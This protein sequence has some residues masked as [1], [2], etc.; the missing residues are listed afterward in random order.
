M[1]D[2]EA[3][4]P[5]D[6][7]EPEPAPAA[8]DPPGPQTGPELGPEQLGPEL[9]PACFGDQEFEDQLEPYH[10]IR[11]SHAIARAGI[12]MLGAGASA[13]RVR[14]LMRKVALSLGMERMQASISFTSVTLTVSRRDIFRT[15]VSEVD[16]P[17]ID[18]QRIA[19]LHQLMH[20]LP[21][22]TTATEVDRRLDEIEAT[23]PVYSGWVVAV[24]V[25][26]A[27]ASVTVLN[28]G[29][30]REAAAAAP[31]SALAYVLH[32]A[33]LR[34]RINLLPTML[35]SAFVT[36]ALFAAFTALLDASLGSTSERMPAGFVCAAIWLVPGFPLVTGG[37]DLTRID[38]DA[39]IPRVVHA[40]MVLLAM[41]IGVWLVAWIVHVS[42]EEIP[43]L[44]GGSALVWTALLA[45]CFFAVT[46]WASVFNSPKKAAVT[47]GVIALIANIPRLIMLEHG[48][49]NHI[50][51]FVGCFLM[52]L[53]CYAA[54]SWLNISKI[55]MTVPATLVT[56]PGSSAL[57]TL[58]YFDEGNLLEAARNG[59]ATTLT[60]IAIVAGLAGARMLTDPEWAF[61]KPDPPELGLRSLGWRRRRR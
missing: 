29:W 17:G 47:A 55:I 28:G 11:R 10:L 41:T 24:L 15:Q 19:L 38:L 51:T 6:E 60:V 52:G 42:P 46:G 22:V 32:R 30:W 3:P 56:I 14:H 21:A 37:L 13:L 33:M 44:R 59:I 23:R 4:G 48:V 27:C 45:A 58:L 31:A 2:A 54:G 5:G 9:D 12:L 16:S 18:S 20:D 61:T 35:L 40:G 25:G 43:P 50:A 7:P 8:E 34:R 49:A 57:R 36:T 26:L 1:N 53:L 39:G